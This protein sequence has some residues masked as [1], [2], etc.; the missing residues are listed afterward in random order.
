M[1]TIFFYGDEWIELYNN[2]EKEFSFDGWKIMAADKNPLIPLTGKI[3]PRSFYL[4]ERDD[5]NTIPNISASQIYKGSLAN[6]GEDLKLLDENNNIIYEIES[7][8][9]W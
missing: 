7:S 5:D 1:G 6:Q 8:D 2:T 9:G 3:L 4:L